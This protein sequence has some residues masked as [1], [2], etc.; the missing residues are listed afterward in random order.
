M[1]KTRTVR[2]CARS[3]SSITASKM[4]RHASGAKGA[5]VEIR[6]RLPVGDADPT[7]VAIEHRRAPVERVQEAPRV[8]DV[9]GLLQ[10]A[11]FVE[12]ER[13]PDGAAVARL[14][15]AGHV[16]EVA[17]RA[18]AQVEARAPREV[19]R[20]VLPRAEAVR[21]LRIGAQLHHR[22]VRAARLVPHVRGREPAVQHPIEGRHEVAH[23]LVVV[24]LLRELEERLHQRAVVRP[25]AAV[26]DVLEERAPREGALV[27]VPPLGQGLEL[28]AVGRREQLG[29]E[30]LVG[31]LVVL[32]DEQGRRVRHDGRRDARRPTSARASSLG[33]A[34]VLPQERERALPRKARAHRSTCT[35]FQKA[36]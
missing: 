32:V 6:H 11:I 7:R 12:H 9:L 1:A 17:E 2:L 23:G 5:G 28:L 27:L 3:T 21:H 36:T 4:P 24:G 33:S 18:A 19:G 14:V 15:R 10:V 26:V 8:E 29:D 20:P 34:H 31:R 25:I 13:G 22:V 30:A 16:A 35:P